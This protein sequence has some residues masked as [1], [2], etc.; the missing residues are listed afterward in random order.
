VHFNSLGKSTTMPGRFGFVT[1]I[2]GGIV[3]FGVVGAGV[4]VVVGAGVVLLVGAG[5]VG[6]GVTGAGVVGLGV[7][8]L[9]GCGVVGAGGITTVVAAA[10]VD[11]IGVAVLD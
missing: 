1:G 2:T 8:V 4:V 11:T 10:A 7:V 5:V 3:G 9:V 6:A